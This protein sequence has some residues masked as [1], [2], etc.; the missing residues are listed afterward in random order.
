MTLSLR[1]RVSRMS[2]KDIAN[3]V[4]ILF[5]KGYTH[6]YGDTDYFYGASEDDLDRA[7]EMLSELQS[8]GI[9]AF[10]KK[11]GV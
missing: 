2:E 5:N 10:E 3:N 11:Y 9:I 6:D 4:L 7:Y 8:Y 1:K